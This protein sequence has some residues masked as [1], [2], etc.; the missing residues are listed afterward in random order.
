MFNN[1]YFALF[2][3]VGCHPA[4]HNIARLEREAPEIFVGS[5]S[6]DP[7]D[8]Y[9]QNWLYAPDGLEHWEQ[10]D[11]EQKCLLGAFFQSDWG[12]R[13]KGLKSG[14]TAPEHLLLLINSGCYANEVAGRSGARLITSN[15]RK[16]GIFPVNRAKQRLLSP[17]TSA[18]YAT[19]VWKLYDFER[20]LENHTAHPLVIHAPQSLQLV[21]Q[22]AWRWQ[23]EYANFYRESGK[24]LDTW[25]G[26]RRVSA[27]FA[28]HEISCSSI[29][30][31]RFHPHTHALVF[32]ED[33][34][35]HF[36]WDLPEGFTVHP[37]LPTRDPDQ[38]R[39]LVGYMTQAASLASTYRREIPGNLELRRE[40]NVRTVNAWSNLVALM[41]AETGGVMATIRR[42][43]ALGLPRMPDEPQQA[44]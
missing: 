41:K 36:A 32:T 12:V 1:D 13:R 6:E 31:G 19:K 5:L 30:D 16:G 39:W 8:R 18:S 15:L 20:L 21:G 43:K 3:D 34:D 11:F 44:E 27:I 9:S 26:K 7:P 28:S 42:I 10:F 2:H 35:P 40:F 25:H 14:Q 22:D 24:L 37:E 33:G 38:V 17:R 23:A 29:W 4:P